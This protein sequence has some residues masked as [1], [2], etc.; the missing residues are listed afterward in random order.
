MTRINLIDSGFLLP[1]RLTAGQHPLKVQ[2]VGSNPTLATILLPSRL[3]AGLE[4]LDFTMVV[5]IHPW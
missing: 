2:D 3:T 4:A 1:S 5:R